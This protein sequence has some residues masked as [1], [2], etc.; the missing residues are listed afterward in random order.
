MTTRLH[1]DT[2]I[3]LRQTE[4]GQA[5]TAGRYWRW[6]CWG[7]GG[8]LGLSLLGNLYLGSLPHW[9]PYYVEIDTCGG[10]VRVV[11]PA[12]ATYTY[13]DLAVAQTIRRFVEGLRVISKDQETTKKAWRSLEAQVTPNGARLLL[14]AA[15]DYDP[16]NKKIPVVVENISVFP[17][18]ARTFYV[19]WQEITF[20]SKVTTTVYSGLFTFERRDPRTP[21]ERQEAPL[22]IFFDDWH[23]SKEG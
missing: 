17:R 4:L 19:R 10:Q 3:R 14:Q 9:K 22:G 5:M 16:L 8:L 18:T 1:P 20:G 13:A 12:P 15:T 21:E 7:V 23:W 2:G 11:G 6:S